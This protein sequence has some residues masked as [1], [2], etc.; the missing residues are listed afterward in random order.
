MIPSSLVI[1]MT[2]KSL[3]FD[4]D[5]V[6]KGLQKYYFFSAGPET[7]VLSVI[8]FRI[9]LAFWACSANFAAGLKYP[10]GRTT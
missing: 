1:R 4:L 6:I 8:F 3:F 7:G 5:I 9:D 2:G 10:Y